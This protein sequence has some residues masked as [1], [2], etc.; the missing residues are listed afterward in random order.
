[1]QIA[2]PA[3][4]SSF[5][6]RLSQPSPVLCHPEWMVGFLRSAALW[7]DDFLLQTPPWQCIRLVQTESLSLFLL[8]SLLRMR[9]LVMIGLLLVFLFCLM[10]MQFLKH[11]FLFFFSFH[12]PALSLSRIF[13]GRQKVF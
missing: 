7:P 1:V 11:R 2:H 10:G 6:C 8:T 12:C 3:F 5:L 9:L 4:A 13:K